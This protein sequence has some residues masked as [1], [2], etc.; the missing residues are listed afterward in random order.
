[1]SKDI[2]SKYYK[3]IVSKFK[4]KGKKEKEFLLEL[5]K[6]IHEYESQ[7]DL[8]YEN[9]VENFG[10]P[11]EVYNSYIEALDENYLTEKL[12][13]KKLLR[14]LIITCIICILMLSLF[15]F[16]KINQEADEAKKHRVDEIETIIEEK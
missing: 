4:F 12:N 11:D 1:M 7:N 9:L 2:I 3:N 14:K 16:Y 8:T 15:I 13:Q 10:T 6:H 5:N